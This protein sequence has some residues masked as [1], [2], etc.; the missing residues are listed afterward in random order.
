MT[1]RKKILVSEWHLRRLEETMALF[2][3]KGTAKS[4][5]KLVAAL[6]EL[7]HAG[8]DPWDLA[9]LIYDNATSVARYGR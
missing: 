1:T 4:E 5:L 3:E 6:E 9:N 2:R 8:V 7:A